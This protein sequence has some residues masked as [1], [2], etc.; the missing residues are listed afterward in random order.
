MSDNPVSEP[1]LERR[2]LLSRPVERLRRM[3][4]IRYA[5]DEIKQLFAAG[6]VAGSTHTCQGQEAIAVG[7]ASVLRPTDLVSCTYR[8]HGHAIALGMDPGTVIAEILGRVDGCVGGVGGSM[9][10]SSRAIGLMPTMAIVGAGIPIAA[11]VA[12]AAQ[13]RGNDDVAVSIFGDGTTNIGAFHEGLNIA[14]VWKLPVVFVCENNLYGEY[15]PLEATTAVK[16]IAERADSYAMPGEIVDG[17]DLDAV[18][19]AMRRAV[20]RARSGGG[21][22]LLE[23]KTYR[24][25]GHS[26]SDPATYRPDGELD[27]WRARDPIEIYGARLTRSGDLTEDD[28]ATMPAAALQAVQAAGALAK[29][30]ARPT[31]GDMFAHVHAG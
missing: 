18:S 22:T 1:A 19:S 31:T 7:I 12:W 16:D 28:L 29:E 23:M 3:M 25:S 4:E 5:E 24:Y 9:H 11:G 15:S 26:R 13:L 10:M 21:P 27:R 20:D 30:S 2:A 14:A 8:G 17:Q 6:L